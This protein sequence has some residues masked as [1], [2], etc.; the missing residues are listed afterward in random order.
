MS[1]RGEDVAA[2]AATDEL[3]D[4]GFPVSTE[5]GSSPGTSWRILAV[6]A[7]LWFDLRSDGPFVRREHPA[8]GMGVALCASLPPLWRTMPARA[9]PGGRPQ[10]LV[11]PEVTGA[12]FGALPPTG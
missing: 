9:T 6:N 1:E 10:S 11:S 12:I 2:D 4:Q 8:A 3:R 7:V 5:S